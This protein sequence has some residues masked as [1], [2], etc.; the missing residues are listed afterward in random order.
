[1]YMN[2]QRPSSQRRL[3]ELEP[4]TREHALCYYGVLYTGMPQNEIRV[5]KMEPCARLHTLRL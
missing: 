2:R 4:L 5:R 1:M 3:C